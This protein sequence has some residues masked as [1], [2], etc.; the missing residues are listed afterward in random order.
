[1]LWHRSTFELTAEQARQGGVL[2]LGPVDAVDQ[3]WINGRIVG[4]TF[5]W[6]DARTYS[7]PA[8]HL[9]EGENVVVVNVLNTYGSGGM[10]KGSPS[11]S[12]L[13]GT[14]DRLSLES[15]RYRKGRTDIGLPPRTPWDPIAGLS[16][17]HNAMLA[18]LHRFSFR[19]VV[20]YQGESD[21]DKGRRYLDFLKALKAQ[22]RD[23]F[24]AD[25]PVLVVQLANYGQPSTVPT[26]SAWAEVREAQRRAT[27]QDSL[28]GLAVTI[29]IGSP[30][31]IHPANKQE[32]GHR[33]ARAG[34]YV[35]YDEDVSPSGPVPA[36]AVRD[37]EGV[38]VVFEEV[39]GTLSARSHDAPIGFEL[40]E[41]E[42]KRCTF[43]EAQIDGR[44]VRLRATGVTA[45]TSV[46]YCW[47]DSP[48]CTLYDEA[49]LPASPFERS[50][51]TE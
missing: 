19:G 36:R 27:Q 42:P 12:F 33:L 17:L 43:A 10:L 41:G 18:P 51:S 5:G 38:T 2:S 4:N 15:W 23:Q 40:C 49:G 32:V 16:T 50:I 24:G 26:E 35:I 29:D 3:T 46:R 45:P 30:Y 7:I 14:G 28:A 13:A 1:M 8:T 25:L 9:R 11:R 6:G 48:V 39:E 37:D 34:R 21:V 31:D 22:W 44:R 47:A 20:W